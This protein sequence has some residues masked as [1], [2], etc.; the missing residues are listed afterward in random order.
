M[1]NRFDFL[2]QIGDW[3]KTIRLQ[4]R[5]APS[6]EFFLASTFKI[7][8]TENR[9]H[10]DFEF[11]EGDVASE[12]IIAL[13][14]GPK[15]IFWKSGKRH[16]RRNRFTVRIDEML[17][18]AT[19]QTPASWT[20]L[21]ELIEAWIGLSYE[22][23]RGVRL[24]GVCFPELALIAA[25]GF[26][27]SYLAH[28]NWNTLIADEVLYVRGN[29]IENRWTSVRLKEAGPWKTRHGERRLEG[30]L[31][32]PHI[33][34]PI[35]FGNTS[36]C[37]VFWGKGLPQHLEFSLSLSTVLQWMVLSCR[38]IQFIITHRLWTRPMIDRS[39]A[40]EMIKS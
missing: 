17:K 7:S 25:S 24:H 35:Y 37:S 39:Q 13:P 33:L 30:K 21:S 18:R 4:A 36:W 8:P 28:R 12:A 15:A 16:I 27:K 20:D 1:M 3:Q 9:G 26:G 38:R 32:A 40:A 23:E 11:V 14:K 31:T 19:Y 29:K 2:V 10:T 5:C 34:P 22:F 6:P